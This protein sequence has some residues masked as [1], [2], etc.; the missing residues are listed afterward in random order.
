MEYRNDV[1]EEPIGVEMDRFQMQ[2]ALVNQFLR[3]AIRNQRKYFLTATVFILVIG[4]GW[5]DYITGPE[6]SLLLLYLMPV[7]ATAWFIGEWAAVVI[8][9]ESAGDDR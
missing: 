2:R 1:Q 8:S 9:V 7:L 5:I 6:Y 3:S 4:L